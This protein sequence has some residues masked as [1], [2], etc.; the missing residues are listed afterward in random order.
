MY[1]PY[2][3]ES[4]AYLEMTCLSKGKK[5]RILENVTPLL[6]WIVLLEKIVIRG[7]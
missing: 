2:P 7:A 4:Q 6:R 5:I 3:A 1:N